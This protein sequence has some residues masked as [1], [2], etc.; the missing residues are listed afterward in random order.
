ME[1]YNIESHKELID[2]LKNHPNAYLFLYKSGHEQSECAL[3]HLKSQEQKEDSL[4]IFVADVAH[5]RDIHEHYD[6]KSVPSLLGFE[7]T[8]FSNILKGCQSVEFYKNFF[9]NDLYKSTEVKGDKEQKS[10]IVYS[11]PTCSWC[12]T[13]KNHLRLHGIQYRDID[14]SQNPE[15]AR[16]MVQ[17]SGQQGVPQTDINGEIIV[18]FDKVRINKLLNING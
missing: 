15:A 18:G 7:K 6:V 10:V 9:A 17:K 14:V 3:D 8:V 11:T 4:P 1:L 16:A 13:L 2:G 12:N 5:V